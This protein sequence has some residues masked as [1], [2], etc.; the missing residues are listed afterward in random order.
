MPFPLKVFLLAVSALLVTSFSQAD[1]KEWFGGGKNFEFRKNLC[2]PG[3][4]RKSYNLPNRRL[5][6]SVTLVSA[7]WVDAN[8]FE[9]EYSGRKYEWLR[10]DP[11][12]VCEEIFEISDGAS[13]KKNRK[14][15]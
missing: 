1:E 15:N 11:A 3:G 5:P 2:K 4:V 8:P 9:I 12:G 6:S 14:E 10:K 13:Q 7:R